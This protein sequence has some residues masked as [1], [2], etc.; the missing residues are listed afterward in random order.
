MS[1]ACVT[2]SVIEV[3]PGKQ[4]EDASDRMVVFLRQRRPA[5]GR[6]SEAAASGR[7]LRRI[8]FLTAAAGQWR[9]Q[10]FATGGV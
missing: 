4:K 10:E 6:R 2:G 7:R 1:L 8:C 3:R 5:V 9:S